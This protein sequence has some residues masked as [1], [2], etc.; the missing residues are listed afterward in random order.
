MPLHLKWR[1]DFKAVPKPVNITEK[2]TASLVEKLAYYAPE[3]RDK[4]IIWC[5]FQSGSDISTVLA[6]NCGHIADEIED[7]PMGAIL[8]RNLVREKGEVPHHSVIY[9]TAVKHLKMYLEERFGKDWLKEV[10]SSKNYDAPLFLGRSGARHHRQY[11]QALLR[12]IAPLTFIANSRFEHADINPLRPHSLRASFNDQMAKEGAVKELRDFIMGHEVPFD[13]AYFGGEEGLRRA[14]VQYAELALEPKGI[15]PDV[16]S[17]L[18]NQKATVDNLATMYAE[19]KKRREKME[20]LIED[21]HKRLEKYEEREPLSVLLK[22]GLPA[23]AFEKLLNRWMTEELRKME[24]DEMSG[25]E[26]E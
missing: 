8:L 21:L 20:A 10:K 13:C 1:E 22:G 18:Q 26:E 17:A 11:Y 5:Q 2:M 14:Y 15:P 3:L 23:E 4:A 7:S 24:E 16:E 6:L 12:E 9:K 25:G 19:E